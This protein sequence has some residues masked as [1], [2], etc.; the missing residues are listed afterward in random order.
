M[1]QLTLTII[2][3]LAILTSFA[4]AQSWLEPTFYLYTRANQGSNE[5]L[6]YNSESSIQASRF[7]GELSTKVITHGYFDSASRG[8]W[9]AE[10]ANKMLDYEG[11][12]LK[13]FLI[14]YFNLN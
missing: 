13:D 5:V 11:K 1:V 8:E 10:M 7:N 4:H 2:A 12:K 9:M 3:V 6:K 14:D